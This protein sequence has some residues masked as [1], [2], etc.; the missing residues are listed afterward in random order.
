MPLTIDKHE[1]YYQASRR[2][3]G[4]AKIEQAYQNCLQYISSF[5][6]AELLGLHFF[7]IGLG[8]I[9]TVVDAGLDK[10]ELMSQSTTL[11][12]EA[13]DL[14][15]A[16]GVPNE[17]GY[18]IIERA[19]DDEMARQLGLDLGT[20]DDS[21]IVLDLAVDGVYLGF[22]TV[23]NQKAEQF[24][25]EHAE[26]FKM[27]H[28]PLALTCNQYIRFRD[29]HR[30]KE[31]IKDNARQMQNDLMHSIGEEVI[32]ADFGL[33]AVMD[34]VRQ[35]A[36]RDSSVLLL[37]ETGVGKEIIA[38]ALHRLSQRQDEAFVKV[39]CG[40]IPPG[41]MESELFGHEKGAFT[42]AIRQRRGCFER[43]DGGTVLLDELGELTPEAQV[44]LLRVLAATNRDLEAMV[45][46]GTFRQDL[47]FRLNVFPIRIP[48]LR[49]RM[50]DIPTLTQHFIHKK[51]RQMGLPDLP[52]S[53]AGAIDRLM[54][55]HWP[56]NVRE[57]ENVVER[58]IIIRPQGPLRFAD[59]RPLAANHRT[60]GQKPD[61]AELVA[62][63]QVLIR[64]ISKVLRKTGGKVEGPGGAAEIL[65]VNPSTLQNR[66]KKLGIP[67]GRQAKGL[68]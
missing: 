54:D 30:L 38:L 64:Y 48:P 56:G 10:A 35:V 23:S 53:A 67:F 33:K 12:A 61:E 40:S 39:N 32:G 19:S 59:I 60:E 31:L 49:K 42:G 1:F 9:E 21:A 2:L 3:L 20:P 5:I 36:P 27:L 24:T 11:T 6:P 8:I 68:Y 15:L 50:A 7:D 34:A 57:L 62:L 58:E 46:A 52:L 16:T 17:P 45:E 37:G 44:R 66:M 13:H 65:Q 55:Y 28:D 41:L 63:D 22:V 4:T 43:A 25:P 51:A 47:F 18:L 29:V 14:V 26:L